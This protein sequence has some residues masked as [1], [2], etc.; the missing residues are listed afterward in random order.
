MDGIVRCNLRRRVRRK[1]RP[2]VYMLLLSNN[3]LNHNRNC[4]IMKVLSL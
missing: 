1:T 2:H 3:Y 4:R